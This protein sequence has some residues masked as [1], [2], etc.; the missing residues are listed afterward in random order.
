[1][2]RLD[3]ILTEYQ[4]ANHA[5]VEAFAQQGKQLSHKTIQK[6]RTGSRPLSRK[7]QVQVVDALNAALALEKPF[8]K[9]DLFP[10]DSSV[11]SS[12]EA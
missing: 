6:A 4:L 12:E 8:R 11:E 5:L 10:R 7:M 3:E 2:T 9:E 1:M